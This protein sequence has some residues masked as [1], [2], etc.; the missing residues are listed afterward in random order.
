MPNS[1]NPA[2][3]P[4]GWPRELFLITFG[5]GV[6]TR[7]AAGLAPVMKPTSAVSQAQA[8]ARTS[9]AGVSC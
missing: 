9:S 6:T 1:H 4:P 5:P 8:A 3:Q 7:A 2:G